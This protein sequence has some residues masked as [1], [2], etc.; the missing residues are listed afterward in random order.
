MKR[1][2]LRKYKEEDLQDYYEL[3]NDENVKDLCHI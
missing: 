2:N 3:V 1:V